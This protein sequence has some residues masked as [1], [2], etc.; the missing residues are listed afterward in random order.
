M[1]LLLE[2]SKFAGMLQKDDKEIIADLGTLASNLALTLS[3]VE[4]Q[5]P[6]YIERFKK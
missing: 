3:D 4:N 1:L 6:K 5:M 2:A